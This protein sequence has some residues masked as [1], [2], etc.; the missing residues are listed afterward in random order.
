[1][2]RY[3]RG[4]P[5]YADA[6]G[7][8]HVAFD[9]HLARTVDVKVLRGRRVEAE[10]RRLDR[11]ARMLGG[12][13]HP[14]LPRLLDVVS[15]GDTLCLVYEHVGTETL[16][17]RVAVALPTT[18]QAVQ[19]TKHVAEAVQ[20]AHAQGI[21]HRDLRPEVIVF[22][23]DD[24]PVV[25]G[26][27]RARLRDAKDA[28]SSGADR[29]DLPTYRAP[30]LF[31]GDEADVRAD[32][33]GV[34]ALLHFLLTGLPPVDLASARDTA[35]TIELLSRGER[36][37]LA[38]H[39]PR[40]VELVARGLASD[41][42]RRPPSMVEVVDALTRELGR[43]TEFPT[44]K[45]DEQVWLPGTEVEGYRIQ[46]ELGRGGFGR[47]YLA[48]DPALGRDVSL[49]F[50]LG[51]PTRARSEARALARI[52]HSN[53]IRVFDLLEHAGSTVLVVEHVLGESLDRR[54][55]EGRPELPVVL[56]VLDQVLAGLEAIHEAGVVHGDLKPANVMVDPHWN[57]KLIDFGL[58]SVP[59]EEGPAPG[60][61][62]PG[63][64]AP[65]RVMRDANALS[66]AADLY[67]FGVLAFELA[68]GRPPFAD[69]TP[70]ATMKAHLDE[71][72]PFLS[73]IAPTLA[74]LGALV[75]SCLE[76]SPARR[77]SSATHAR[78]L[79]R[80]ASARLVAT[81]RPRRVL[82]VD[83]N[84][85]WTRLLVEVLTPLTDGG[86]VE[87]AHDGETGLALARAGAFDLVTLDLQLPKRNGIELLAELNATC[88]RPPPVV[89]LS[90]EA[91]T[92]S[93]RW[94]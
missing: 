30:E 3:R 21:V 89:L 45:P 20:A 92:C 31:V 8:L 7:A 19:W 4:E 15:D 64:A 63:Y 65:E 72:P 55:A 23:G 42:A 37:R 2:S 40:L 88:E 35:E 67:A 90:G 70:L 6:G 32:V 51:D 36:R 46:T 61:L 77:P 10:R 41:P 38:G 34:V 69:R 27:R 71:R 85:A 80:E 82:V 76:K 58:A 52:R 68:S 49:K 78:E 9:D 84:V 91:S 18:R 25:H 48:T 81:R 12:A 13:L 17:A 74:P 33:Y 14:G 56:S 53:V 54:L 1:M 24:I 43:D 39:S 93:R 83:D 29:L 86:G 62:T 79:L 28:D 47:V 26:F 44:A 73:D 75:G 60:S 57:V 11:E 16:A 66:V 94:A 50:V 22:G 87:V 59:G 5:I